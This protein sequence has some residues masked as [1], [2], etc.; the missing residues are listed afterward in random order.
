MRGSS[1]GD[2]CSNISQRVGTATGQHQLA[3]FVQTPHQAI[4]GMNIQQLAHYLGNGELLFAGQ[5]ALA[6][7]FMM[8][9]S[10]L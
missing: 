4:A 9:F 10:L 2:R 3:L 8:Y 7:I 1:G 6:R 5:G